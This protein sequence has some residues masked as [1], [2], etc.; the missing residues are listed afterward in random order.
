MNSDTALT[1]LDL[2]IQRVR[3]QV[4]GK[5]VAEAMGISKGRLSRIEKPERVTEQMRR[6]Y[7]DALEKCRTSGTGAA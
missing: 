5:A 3:L 7:L 6:R 4:T 2:K 1:G